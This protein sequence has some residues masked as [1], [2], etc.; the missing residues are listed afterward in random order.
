MVTYRADSRFKTPKEGVFKGNTL[1]SV[2]LLDLVYNHVI[3][4][5]VCGF[6][7]Y[8]FGLLVVGV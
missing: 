7:H 6:G 5:S 4:F 2:S 3:Y 8:D 1:I